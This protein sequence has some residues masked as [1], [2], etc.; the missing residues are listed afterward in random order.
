MP[1]PLEEQVVVITGASS[2][3]GRET[4]WQ[5]ARRGALVVAAA[6]N[7]DALQRLQ[8]DVLEAGGN[9]HAV[10]CDVARWDDVV[11]LADEAVG[12]FGR[13]DTWINNAGVSLYG[14]IEDLPVDEIERVIQV[15]LM[16]VVHGCKA[17]IPHLRFHGGGTI[18]NVGSAIS[19]RAVPLQGPYS[20]A[21]AGV[22]GFSE[23]LRMELQHAEANIDVVLVMPSSINTPFFENARSRMGRMAKPIPPVYEASAVAEAIV[24]A[25]EEPQRDIHVGSASWLMGV[26]EEI[27]P[28]MLDRLMLAGGSMFRQQQADAPPPARDN[29]FEPVPGPGRVAGRWGELAPASSPWTRLV[30]LNPTASKLVAGAA[31]AGALYWLR[32]RGDA[33]AA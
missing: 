23:A 18:I 1:R 20:A 7:L 4:A 6:R 13:I 30:E 24:H 15:D 9:L 31:I 27:S 2:G 33:N 3:I 19:N 29:L 28:A 8:R 26:G 11:K 17:A 22:R 16:G 5:L 14:P 25:C 10:Q 21:K 12:R 32:S